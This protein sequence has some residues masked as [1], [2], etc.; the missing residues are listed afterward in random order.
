VKFREFQETQID[1]ENDA[2]PMDLDEEFEELF[3][4]EQYDINF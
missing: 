1:I 2:A 4:I 3:K